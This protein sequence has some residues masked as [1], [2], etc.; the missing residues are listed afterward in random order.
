M[1]DDQHTE[2]PEQAPEVPEP[3]PETPPWGDDFDPARAWKTIQSLRAREKELAPLAQQAK[4]QEDAQKSEAERLREERDALKAE[5]DTVRLEA[6]RLRIAAEK[7]LTPKQAARLRG[8]TEEELS[9]DADELLAEFTSPRRFGDVDQGVKSN[10]PKA[11]DDPKA[12]AD[13]VIAQRGH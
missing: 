11:Q 12:L 6:M 2:E 13:A 5:R 8:D 3:K 1:S 4:E 7:G 9:A 10:G